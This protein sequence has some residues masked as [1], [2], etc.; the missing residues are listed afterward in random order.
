MPELCAAPSRSGSTCEIENSISMTCPKMAAK[1][2]L[3][4]GHQRELEFKRH[5]LGGHCTRL[6]IHHAIGRTLVRELMSPDQ[7]HSRLGRRTDSIRCKMHFNISTQEENSCPL[8]CA[9]LHLVRSLLGACPR[10]FIHQLSQ[11]LNRDRPLDL[12]PSRGCPQHLQVPHQYYP[13]TRIG[14]LRS[15]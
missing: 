9:F 4:N 8:H 13:S 5:G 1:S 12:K 2:F 3:G 6:G 7:W 15:V 10:R 11:L 14:S